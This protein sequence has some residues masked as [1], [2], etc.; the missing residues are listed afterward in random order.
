[1]PAVVSSGQYGHL[2]RTF[3]DPLASLVTEP[4]ESTWPHGRSIGGLSAVAGS[5]QHSASH[6]QTSSQNVELACI[7]SRCARTLEMGQQK[8]EWC[9]CSLGS[10]TSTGSCRPSRHASLY[11]AAG[12][13]CDSLSSAGS[14]LTPASTS[15]RSGG[16][17]GNESM[18]RPSAATAS[19]ACAGGAGG[20]RS[21]LRGCRVCCCCGGKRG[22]GGGGG[23]RLGPKLRREERF[24]RRRLE[25]A[26]ERER[27]HERAQFSLGS[28][29]R[30]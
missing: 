1:M 10:G 21:C 15:D 18:P 8:T 2:N 16:T 19:R 9:W 23:G 7:Q 6:T 12:I 30:R 20:A 25:S 27:A 14:A 26:A 11:L 3:R 17:W 22:G 4:C 29:A 28:A 5:C 13:T 24:V